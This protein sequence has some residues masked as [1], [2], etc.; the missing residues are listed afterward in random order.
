MTMPRDSARRKTRNELIE[1]AIPQFESFLESRERYIH[2]LESTI[3]ALTKE[4][5]SFNRNNLDIRDSIDEA[6]R[7]EE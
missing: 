6:H 5:K 3:E 1:E 2:A 4:N 7:D